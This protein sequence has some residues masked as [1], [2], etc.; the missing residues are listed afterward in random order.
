MPT[1]ADKRGVTPSHSDRVV[2]AGTFH[3]LLGYTVFM[4]STSAASGGVLHT[5]NILHPEQR[6]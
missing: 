4:T 5:E 1:F 3:F 2:A 6:R